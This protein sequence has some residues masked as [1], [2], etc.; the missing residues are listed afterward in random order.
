MQFQNC[1]HAAAAMA[2]IGAPWQKR[3]DRWERPT[4][5]F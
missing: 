1:P 3:A 4:V 2:N 5:W